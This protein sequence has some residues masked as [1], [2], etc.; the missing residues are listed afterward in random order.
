MR[1]ILCI[2]AIFAVFGISFTG[3]FG[4]NPSKNTNVTKVVGNFDLA[5]FLGKWY[6]VGVQDERMSSLKNLSVNYATS[7]EK[8]KID[9]LYEGIDEKTK[10]V[11]K[12]KGDAKFVWNKNIGAMEAKIYNSYMPYNVVKVD[13]NY[14]YALIYGEDRKQIWFLSRTKNM[15]EVIKAV[16]Q[17]YAKD[18]GYDVSDIVWNTKNDKK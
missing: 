2:A 13:S 5:S 18:S 3:C 11:K 10:K 16:Y 7:L 12:Y 9:I 8:N 14:K 1:K 4:K 17:N 6:V 15:P